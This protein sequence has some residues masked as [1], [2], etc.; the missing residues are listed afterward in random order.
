[1]QISQRCP[2][3]G[4]KIVLI[5][6]NGKSAAAVYSLFRI[7]GSYICVSIAIMIL[8]SIRLSRSQVFRNDFK[9][10][11]SPWAMS[12][13]DDRFGIIWTESRVSLGGETPGNDLSLLALCNCIYRA[14]HI[15]NVLWTPLRYCESTARRIAIGCSTASSPARRGKCANSRVA[16]PAWC[17]MIDRRPRG[18]SALIQWQFVVSVSPGALW[19]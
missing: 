2:R 19:E 13:P 1:M 16:I 10:Q 4:R 5:P 8:F 18:Y 7:K 15:I 11:T 14:R 3:E 17:S 9:W 12:K 6:A